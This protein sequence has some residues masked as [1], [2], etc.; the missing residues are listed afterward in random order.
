M[1]RE[2][3]A[4][5]LAQAHSSPHSYSPTTTHSFPSTSPVRRE[6]P[7]KH[8]TSPLSPRQIFQSR[9]RTLSDDANLPTNPTQSPTRRE[10]E[11]QYLYGLRVHVRDPDVVDHTHQTRT[12]RQ[13]RSKDGRFGF[14]PAEP[15]FVAEERAAWTTERSGKKEIEQETTAAHKLPDRLGRDI[16][17][18]ELEQGE[19]HRQQ[20][21]PTLR[22][23]GPVAERLDPDDRPK[24]SRGRSPD[25]D[26][27]ACAFPQEARGDAQEMRRSKFL[28]GSMSERSVGVASTWIQ[29]DLK[30]SESSLREGNIEDSDATPCASRASRD[31]G[32]FFDVSEFRPQPINPSTIRGKLARLVKRSSEDA[33]KPP[34]V[35]RKP[36]SRGLRKSI[37]TWSFHNIGDKVKFFG[38]SSSD[39]PGGQES[40]HKDV[41]NAPW[42]ELNERKR[43][44]EEAYAQQF[45]MKKQKSNNGIPVLQSNNLRT[46]AESRTLERRFVSE[47]TITPGTARIADGNYQNQPPRAH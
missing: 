32:S 47:R 16:E 43:K 10:G 26:S 4:A 20:H 34:E 12:P 27:L 6:R 24:T 38:A 39:L 37:S 25:T 13:Y 11:L 28:E 5:L 40:P 9:F 42:A 17:T 33:S 31:S 30:L 23:F 2:E 3:L 45:G 29:H 19:D 44:A 46:A 41:P 22:P 21:A 18:L 8:S 1:D 36:R 35:E 14:G 15:D 7:P